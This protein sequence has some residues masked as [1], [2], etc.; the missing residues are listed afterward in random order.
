MWWKEKWSPISSYHNEH[1]CLWVGSDE[2]CD[3]DAALDDYKRLKIAY[4]TE[5]AF[6]T[7]TQV[8]P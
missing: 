8:Y 6:I 3:F 5:M 7:K 1:E 4:E 2:Y